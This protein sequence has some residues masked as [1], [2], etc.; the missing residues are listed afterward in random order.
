MDAGDVPNT[1]P[2]DEADI[3]VGERNHTSKDAVSEAE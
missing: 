3:E 1:E 2:A